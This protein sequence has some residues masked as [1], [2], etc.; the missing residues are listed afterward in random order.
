MRS[1]LPDLRHAARGLLRSPTVTGAAILCLGLGLGATTAIWSAVRT[2]LLQPLPFPAPQELVTV[3]RT[4]PHFNAGPFSLPNWID[5][6][7]ET[8]TIASL[9]AVTPGTA[10]LTG[11][12]ESRRITAYRTSDNLFSMLRAAALRGRLFESGDGDPQQPL[13]T[14]ISEELWRDQFGADPGIVGRPLRLNG[15]EYEV[16]GILPAAFRVPHGNQVLQSD[17]WVTLRYSPAQA[18]ARRNNFL[19]AMGRLQPGTSVDAADAEL[20]AVMDRIIESNPELRGEQLRVVPLHRES[21]R[22]VRGPLMMLLGA[23]GFVLWIAAANVASLLLARGVGRQRDVAVRAVLGAGRWDVVRPALLESALLT[24]V[25]LAL[26][27]GIA[28]TGVRLIGTLAAARLPQL[29]GLALDLRVIGFAVTVAAIVSCVCGVAPA[30]QASRG[31]P[32]EALRSGGRAGTGKRHHRFLRSIVAVEVALSLVLLLGAGLVLRGF[33]R[34]VSQDPGFDPAT[35]LTLSVH[36]PPENYPDGASYDGFLLPALERIRALPGVLEAGV[37][38]LIP[39]ASW[40]NNFNMRY[41]GQPGDDPT[42]LPLVETRVVTASYFPTMGITLRRGSLFRDGESADGDLVVV[43]NQALADAHFPNEDPIGKRFHWGGDTSFA[44]IIGIVDDIRNVGPDRATAAEVY[45]SQGRQSRGSAA[46][47]LIVRTAGDPLQFVRPVTA[48]IRSQ[49]AMAAIGQVRPMN[50]VIAA[51]VGRPRFYLLLLG[52]FAASALVLAVAGLYGVMS[53]AVAQR[54]REIGIRAALGSTPR[55]TVGMVVRQGMQLVG[56]GVLIGLL[57]GTAL[58]RLLDTLL[59]G[60]SPLDFI[61]WALVTM[62]L[63]GASLLAILVP[64]QRASTV[65][66]LVAIRDE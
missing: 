65:Q 10:L 26:G 12:T 58:T 59:Y 17:V 63:A 24:V 37:I 3:Y 44:T 9:A 16:L 50:D 42:T 27:L 25:G 55:R 61:T 33:E 22:A 7:R 30:L 31:D 5:L 43:A 54:R 51:A 28:W 34:L 14:V 36:V 62:A 46:F 38:S 47:S 64:A 41:E 20:R 8:R 32:Q 2:A 53:Y 29:D 21:V 52:A 11:A 45:W 60:V 39:Y 66:P 48:A 56:G 49:E 13:V 35:L 23:V 18:A 4:T 6:R 15:E 1:F 57:G 40:G 19:M